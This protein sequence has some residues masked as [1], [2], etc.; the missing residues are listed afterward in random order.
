MGGISKNRMPAQIFQ[1]T[2][3][4][5]EEKLCYVMCRQQNLEHIFTMQGNYVVRIVSSSSD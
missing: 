3:Q 4:T 5:V 2:A 1:N